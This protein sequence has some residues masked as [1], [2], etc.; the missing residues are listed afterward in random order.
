MSG[1]LDVG[2]GSDVVV[3]GGGIVGTAAAAFLAAAGA[4]VTLVEGEGLASGASGA[5][6]GVVQHPFDP[7]LAGLY[8]ETVALYRE[9]SA[10][11]LGFRLPD[12]PAGLLYLSADETAVRDVDRSLAE[13]L[14]GARP[15]GRQR[16]RARAT[17][18]GRCCRAVG[19]PGR[20]RF[21]GLPRRLD[22]RLRDA[23]RTARRHGPARTDRLPG[24]SR[25]RGRRRHRRWTAARL[26]RR[27]RR[28]RTVV[29]RAH[30]SERPLDPDPPSV[31][32]RRRGGARRRPVACARGG[33]DRRRDRRAGSGRP[34][35]RRATDLRSRA[36]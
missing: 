17:R 4:S 27:P 35:G 5:N 6:S 33:R 14:S 16:G 11:D 2:A 20:D 23:R 26:R 31:G 22:L 25:R 32:R 30:R 1:G 13:S 7:V 19:V 8:R 9:L 3:I 29:A 18:A 28:G 34:R 10:A 36:R 12:E 15:V 21:P 24:R